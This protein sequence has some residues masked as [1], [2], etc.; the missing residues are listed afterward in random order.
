MGPPL[1]NFASRSLEKHFTAEIAADAEK[2]VLT[3]L[4]FSAISAHWAVNG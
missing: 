2:T 4:F 3:V 1:K